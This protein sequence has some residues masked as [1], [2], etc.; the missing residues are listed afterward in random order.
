MVTP[1]E[2]TECACCDATIDLYG[3][4]YTHGADVVCSP[5]CVQIMHAKEIADA[6]GQ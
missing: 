4:V 6:A 5:A 3:P 1:F 2:F